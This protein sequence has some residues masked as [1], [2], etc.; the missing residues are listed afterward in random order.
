MIYRIYPNASPES[1]ERIPIMEKLVTVFD[2]IQKL[3]HRATDIEK[4][5][6]GKMWDDF[7]RIRAKKVHELDIK[8]RAIARLRVYFNKKLEILKYK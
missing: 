8:R 3:E 7:P 5:L 4:Q 6:G 2:W 1:L